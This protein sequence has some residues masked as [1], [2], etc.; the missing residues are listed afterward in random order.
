M[1]DLDRVKSYI[2]LGFEK[3]DALKMVDKEMKKEKAEKPPIEEDDTQDVDLSG[4]VKKEDVDK[5]IEDAVS[6]ALEKKALE[7][8]EVDPPEKKDIG[9]LINKFF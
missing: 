6:K 1:L 8:A 5:Q 4:Y 3:E 2:E 9:E 7:K